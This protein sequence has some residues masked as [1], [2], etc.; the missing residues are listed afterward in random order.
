MVVFP[1]CLLLF[2]YFTTTVVMIYN[3]LKPQDYTLTNKRLKAT[4]S[5]ALI[6]T[7]NVSTFALFSKY[8]FNLIK[9]RISI[10]EYTSSLKLE[11]AKYYYINTD[12][13]AV[14]SLPPRH[15]LAVCNAQGPP[16]KFRFAICR[17]YITDI[18]LYQK[19]KHSYIINAK[20]KMHKNANSKCTILVIVF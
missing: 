9:S 4:R 8:F 14:R 1:M 20:L 6:F 5:A 10:I 12:N 3:L 19:P 2:Y 7:L 15:L 16:K 18:F 13:F 11:K 17:I